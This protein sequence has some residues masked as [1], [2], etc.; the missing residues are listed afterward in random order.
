MINRWSRIVNDWKEKNCKFPPFK[1]FVKFITKGSTI[2]CD[3]I[4]SI[5]VV[6]N[7]ERQVNRDKKTNYRSKHTHFVRASWSQCQRSN[8]SKCF[9]CRGSHYLD[10]CRAFIVKTI[11][12]RRGFF[13]DR[14]LCFGCLNKGHVLKTST[15]SQDTCQ[16]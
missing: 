9:M 14:G 8:V 15:G 4:T 12:E 11:S 10:D 7:T 6:K 5:L 2:A 13:R 16:Q 3:P 1:E